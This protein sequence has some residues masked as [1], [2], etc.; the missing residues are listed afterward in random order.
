MPRPASMPALS[1]LVP[2][3]RTLRLRRARGARLDVFHGRLW[4]TQSG[5]NEDA[6]LAAGDTFDV[7]AAGAIVIEAD[8]NVPAWITWGHAPASSPPRPPG[9]GRGRAL[10]DALRARL[11]ALW[12]RVAARR[13]RR[14][15]RELD[16]RLMR[17][18]GVPDAVREA[19]LASRSDRQPGN[20]ERWLARCTW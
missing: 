9:S 19:V 1:L 12:A 15:L 13:T 11:A 20:R 3:G 14:S 4:L 10:K 7:R 5:Q 8:G 18:A 2:P 16:D 6:F 17:D